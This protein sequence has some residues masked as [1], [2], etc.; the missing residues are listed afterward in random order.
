MDSVNEERV[1]QYDWREQAKDKTYA[2][3]IWWV[4]TTVWLATK[5]RIGLK[6]NPKITASL[7]TKIIR[8]E[9][10]LAIAEIL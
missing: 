7:I 6:A 10:S 2:R 1:C 5:Q 9:K 3:R 8:V 4:K